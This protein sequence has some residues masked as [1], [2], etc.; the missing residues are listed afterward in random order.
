M[1][2][3]TKSGNAGPGRSAARTKVCDPPGRALQKSTLSDG[4]GTITDWFA[5]GRKADDF[6]LLETPGY[7]LRR[8][9]QRAVEL[10]T[11]NRKGSDLTPRQFVAMMAV[12][13][14]PGLSQADLVETTAID[15]STVAD[16]VDRL[17]GRGLIRRQRSRRDKRINTLSLTPKGRAELEAAI[18]RATMTQREILKTIPADEREC[19]IR[20]LRRIAGLQA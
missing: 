15:R 6:P 12:Y 16:V 5:S 7:L 18:E 14:D 20:N 9:H 3:P 1:R 19:F 8:A 2:E 17:T 11:E 4:V 10:F 13:K